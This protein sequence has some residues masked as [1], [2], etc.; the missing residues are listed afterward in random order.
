VYHAHFELQRSPFSIAP[1]PHFLYMS[2]R[3]RDALAHLLWGLEGDGGFVLLTGEVGTGKTTLSRC[4]L[5]QIPDDTDLAFIINPR[6]TVVE[7]LATVCDE[8]GVPAPE[9]EQ[10][11]VKRL[12]DRI[13]RHLL[14][15]HARG[16]RTVL[17]I[18]EAQ[19]LSADV[20]EQIRLLTNL[21]TSE[22]KLLQVILIG[23]PEL[24]TMLQR[25]ELRQ[26]SQR[27]TA[28]YH[29][30]PLDRS[31][32]ASLIEHRMHVAGARRQPFTRRALARLYRHSRGIPR[33]ANV[34]ADRAL[35]GTWAQGRERVTPRIVERAAREVLGNE[36]TRGRPGWRTAVAALVLIGLVSAAAV[37][38]FQ[39]RIPDAFAW[40]ADPA[41]SDSGTASAKETETTTE[42]RASSEGTGAEPSPATAAGGSEPIDPP[43]PDPDPDPGRLWELDPATTEQQAMAA[44]LAAWHSPLEPGPGPVC[45]R[46]A[47][48]GL[49]CLRQDGNLASLIALDRPAMLELG[50][51]GET[52]PRY[53]ALTAIEDGTPRVRLEG[54]SR[55]LP[56]AVLER[57]WRGRATVL[58]QLPPSWSGSLSRGDRGPGVRWLRSRLAAITDRSGTD[59]GGPASDRFDAELAQRLRAFQSAQ[60]LRPDGIAGPQTWIRINSLSAVGAPS[61]TT[62]GEH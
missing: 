9:A 61:L 21:E 20:L 17:V 19:N 56:P 14:D 53:L 38:R 26:L 57:Y 12:V 51:A 18:D 13:N 48:V 46:V 34:I 49:G 55:L 30:E 42:D 32:L 4:L 2:E 23:Q 11:S 24:A 15:A 7:L 40:P 31:S 1:D 45:D 35:L 25:S 27:I 58:W 29:L 8:L 50:R 52:S 6:V 28:R 47:E 39:D 41:G 60:G 62:G 33:L 54:E 10:T 16:R 59:P 22:R 37:I 3:H 5:E 43:Q 36:S 44:L